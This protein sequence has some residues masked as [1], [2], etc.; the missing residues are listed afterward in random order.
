[1]RAISAV[2]SALAVVTLATPITEPNPIANIDRRDF[3]S[4]ILST[5]EGVVDCAG[6][7]V[8]SLPNLLIDL[9]LIANRSGCLDFTKRPCCFGKYN[10]CINSD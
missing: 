5:I 9:I 7:E 10:F 8:R 6:G 3:A 4:T 1:M 2:I